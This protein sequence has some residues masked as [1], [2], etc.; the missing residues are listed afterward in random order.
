MRDACRR[1]DVTGI[2]VTSFAIGACT[3]GKWREYL[4]VGLL[5]TGTFVAIVV[6]VWVSDY[7]GWSIWLRQFFVFLL[8]VAILFLNNKLFRKNG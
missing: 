4:L 1:V 2:V 5:A 3:L 7:L 8:F 6:I